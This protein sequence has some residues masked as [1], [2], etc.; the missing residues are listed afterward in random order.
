M[1][2]PGAIVPGLCSV[3]FRGLEPEAVIALAALA[4]LG[5]IEWGT[6]IHLPPGDAAR[7]DA[8]AAACRD[9]GLATHTLGSYLRF[10][11]DASG[12]DDAPGEGNVP[13]EVAAVLDT[14][15]R[16]GARRVRVWAGRL[17]SA[18]A[19]PDHRDRVAGALRRGCEAA[20]ARGLGL[21]LEFHH[22][23]LTD[24]ARSA[25]ALMDAVD[26]PGL[27]T[28]WQPRSGGTPG[29]ALDALALLGPRLADLHVFHWDPDKRRLPLAHGA[30]FWTRVLAALPPPAH[31]PRHAFLEFVAGDDPD[32]LRED[33]ATLRT[34]LA[35]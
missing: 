1:S 26:H 4:G 20:E 19:T 2:G 27:S 9:A 34:W 5:A 11:G 18:A 22:D 32:R 25:A 3:T 28:Y 15:L 13:G 10:E 17:G 30:D 23:T 35:A 12:E 31:P 29:E 6:D 24:T 21:A 33:A 7:A 8:V 16:L 14:A